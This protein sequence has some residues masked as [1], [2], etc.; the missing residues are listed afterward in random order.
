M[1]LI[2]TGNGFDLHHGLNTSYYAFGYF[3]KRNKK[4]LYDD[5][6]E[7][8]YLPDLPSDPNELEKSKHHLWSEFESNLAAFDTQSVLESF[9]EYRPNVASP[10][11][12]DGEWH[13]FSIVMQELLEEITDGLFTQFKSFIDKVKY[14]NI[15]D[16]IKLD[17][18]NKDL[19]INFN[20]TNTLQYY[21]GIKNNQ[22]LYLHGN[23]SLPDDSLILGHGIDP[24][25]FVETPEEAPAGATY[26]ELER[27][28][29]Y[30]SDNYDIAFESGKNTINQYFKKSFKNTEDV[31]SSAKEFFS[32]LSQVNEVIIIGHSLSQVDMP[33]FSA[34]KQNVQF[35]ATWT[36]TWY[37]ENE[38]EQHRL[39]LLNVGIENPQTIPISSLQINLTPNQNDI[40][41]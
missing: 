1:R 11:F 26:E 17:L 35:N 10:D 4:K 13:T 30:M 8:F 36:V 31:I 27:W 37:F 14:P 24:E 41:L 12:S 18:D 38:R 5:L 21:Y 28:N 22:I 34:I 33:Y 7:Y 29:Q 32:Y 19:F 20:Y 23:A 6:I 15:S 40:Q 25:N 2:V 39:A 16:Q 9:D 3:L